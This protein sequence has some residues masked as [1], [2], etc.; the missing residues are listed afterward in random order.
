[1][2]Y[3]L[4]RVPWIETTV[5]N[6]L[7][8]AV[9]NNVEDVRPHHVKGSYHPLQVNPGLLCWLGIPGLAHV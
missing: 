9:N 5:I 8:E 2:L 1:M 7:R 6:S 4:H 3:I